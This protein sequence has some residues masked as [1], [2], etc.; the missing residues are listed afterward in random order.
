[1]SRGLQFF[2]I[3]FLPFLS[4]CQDTAMA[5]SKQLNIITDNDVYLL[6]RK[7]GYYTNGLFVQ[8]VWRKKERIHSID[9]GHR[10]YTS[11][12]IKMAE[13]GNF[14][15]PF[16]GLIHVQYQQTRFTKQDHMLKWGLMLAGIGEMAFAKEFQNRY[17]HLIGIY[18]VTGWSKQLKNEIGL[19]ASFTWSPYIYKSQHARDLFAVKPVFS[20]MLGST[21][22]HASFGNVLQFGLF[23]ENA[24][25]AFWNTGNSRQTE[26]YAY[27]YPQLVLTG[28]NATVQGGLFRK[29]KGPLTAPVNHVMYRHVIGFA[30]AKG[31]IV[32]GIDIIYQGK[33]A[34]TQI[35]QQ[36]YASIRMGYRFN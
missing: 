15:R 9:I 18:S 24:T 28:Y 36:R 16:A 19:N 5:Y 21:F 7:D 27:F 17:H 31:R 13:Q 6:D 2:L 33:E 34:T 3:S 26:L 32:S 10:M 8:Y 35:A 20:A 25:S 4:F 23:N 29:D 1:M 14:D 22:T 30:Y 12:T 11:K